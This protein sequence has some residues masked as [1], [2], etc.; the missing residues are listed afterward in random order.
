[1]SCGTSAREGVVTPSGKAPEPRMLRITTSPMHEDI[2]AR[3]DG[4]R[5]TSGRRVVERLQIEACNRWR[6]ANSEKGR[7]PNQPNDGHGEEATVGE[8]QL[9]GEKGCQDGHT[10]QVRGGPRPWPH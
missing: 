1:M 7:Q 9:Q 8:C 3:I 2:R 5:C 6:R 4:E 10:W